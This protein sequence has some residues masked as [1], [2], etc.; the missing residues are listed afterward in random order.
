MNSLV[1]QRLDQRTRTV[2]KKRINK[3]ID[4]VNEF[5]AEPERNAE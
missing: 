3:K 4:P 2:A 1:N 5:F